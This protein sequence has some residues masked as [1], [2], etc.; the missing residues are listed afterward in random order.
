MTCK[1]CKNYDYCNKREMLKFEIYDDV[2]L[3][4]PHLYPYVESICLRF[5]KKGGVEE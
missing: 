1:E 2:W 3:D 4:E 5:K